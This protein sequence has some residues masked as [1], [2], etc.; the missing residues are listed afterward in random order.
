LDN[1]KEFWDLFSFIPLRYLD[2]KATIVS[3]IDISDVKQ[4]QLDYEKA[5]LAAEEA[6]KAKSEF[7]ANMSHEIRTS[8]NAIMGL[9]HLALMTDLDDKQKDYLMKND[10][11][12]QSLLG[13]INDILDFSKIEAGK[14][15]LKA[16]DIARLILLNFIPIC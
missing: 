11:S 8:M 15:N 13:I 14:L 4:L 3:F 10:R 1:G 9:T 12:S 6:T 7:L 2:L 5:E 16:I